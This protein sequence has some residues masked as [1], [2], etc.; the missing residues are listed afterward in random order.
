MKQLVS[1][2]FFLMLSFSCEEKVV[3]KKS[4]NSYLEY[5]VIENNT[6]KVLDT[7]LSDYDSL[8]LVKIDT[9]TLKGKRA[10]IL[11]QFYLENPFNDRDI[12]TLFDVNYDG[13]KD[14]IIPYYHQSGTGLKHA[15]QIYLYSKKH[16]TY[17]TDSLLSQIQN[18][19]FYIQ[20]KKITGF[21]I[22]MGGGSGQELIW[23]NKIWQIHKTFEVENIGNEYGDKSLWTISYPSINKTEKIIKAYRMIPY[24]EILETKIDLK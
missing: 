12:D 15:V 8:S 22:G 20:K 11:N 21:Y 13:F 1:I 10:Y 3:R 9:S 6:P 14:F 5:T 23:K 18:P 7:E 16:N 19:S 24:P 2:L 17:F 4:H